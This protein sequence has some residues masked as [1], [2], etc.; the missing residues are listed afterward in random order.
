MD[1]YQHVRVVLATLVG[2]SLTRLVGGVAQFTQHGRKRVYWVHLVWVLYMILYTIAFW[3]W[4]FQLETV[5]QWTFPLYAF[6]VLY[7][8]LVYLL[9]ALLFPNGLEE[10]EGFRGY[11]YSRRNWFFGV[12]A[13]MFITDLFDTSMKGGAHFKAL[14]LEYDLRIAAYLVC[15]LIA[16]LVKSEGFHAAFAVIATLYEIVFYLHQFFTFGPAAAG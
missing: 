15:C 4:E 2:F 13:A 12:M 7:G 6:L 9:C 5:P 10:Y 8:I 14:G 1:L 3:W 16:I 11:F